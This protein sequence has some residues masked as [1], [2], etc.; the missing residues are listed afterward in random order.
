MRKITVP[1]LVKRVV[2]EHDVAAITSDF[3]PLFKDPNPRRSIV[4]SPRL[5]YWIVNFAERRN[6]V[7]V[8]EE[9]GF[10]RS[11]IFRKAKK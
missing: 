11:E 7:Y 3:L 5:I 10:P 4:L 2:L 8:H 6:A 1:V 9:H